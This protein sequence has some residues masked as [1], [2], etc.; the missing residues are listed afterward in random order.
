MTMDTMSQRRIMGCFATGVTLITTGDGE[1]VCGMTANAFLSLS[2]DPPLVL[3]AVGRRNQT[4]EWLLEHKRFAVNVLAADQEA[5]AR[6]F[7]KPGPKD[8]SDLAMRVVAT[9][10]PV[11]GEAL[12]FVDCRVVEILPAGDHDIFIGEV[13][14]GDSREGDPLLFYRGSYAKLQNNRPV[15][16]RQ[17]AD[18]A[19]GESADWDFCF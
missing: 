1:S 15:E 19:D 8:F 9:G 14:A 2:L 11:I 6:R 3:V 17:Q 10:A 12:A 5:L 18:T 4:R 7:A 13:L 16:P